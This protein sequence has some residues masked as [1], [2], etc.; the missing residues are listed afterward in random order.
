MVFLGFG[1]YV[2]ADKIYAL[3]PIRGDGPGRRQAGRSSGW[4]GSPSR[5]SPRGPSGR[6]SSRWGTDR[7]RRARRL[8]RRARRVRRADRRSAAD[9]GRGGVD[10]DE[11]GRRARKLLEATRQAGRGRAALLRRERSTR[12]LLRA[13][14]PRGR[15][16][17]HRLH[18]AR[19]R[20]R[21]AHRRG[22]GL[23]PDRPGEPQ[24]SAGRRRGTASMFG[25]P[26]HAYV[27]RSYGIHWCLNLVCA[28]RGSPRP[29]SCGRSSRR[30]ARGDARAARPRRRAPPLLRA[31]A[32]L[33]G[34]RRHRRARRPAARRAAVRAP[35]RGAGPVEIVRGAARRDHA[36]GRAP[37][38]LRRS[39][40][41]ASSA[42]AF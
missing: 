8:A 37:V 22:R 35:C 24:L 23:R 21:R 19:R 29:C 27:Y 7:G 30:G 39:P 11:L 6:S 16:G 28:R 13:Q 14:R 34:A 9:Q 10:L 3:E 42:A 17:A 26:G 18:A 25:P 36:R 31:R 5:S 4:T 40:A 12:G 15:A 20:R 38:A 1:K 2:R 32:A 41:R 33:P